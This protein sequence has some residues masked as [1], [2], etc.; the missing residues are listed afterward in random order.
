MSK[1]GPVTF[2]KRQREMEKKKEAEAKRVRRVERAK[3]GPS[4]PEIQ[5]CK[6]ILDEEQP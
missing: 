2:A 1:R 3:L 5:I 6:P 4:E